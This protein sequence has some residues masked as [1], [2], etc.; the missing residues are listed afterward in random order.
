MSRISHSR[1]ILFYVAIIGSVLTL[2][3]M[4]SVY[5]EAN[6]K[7]PPDLNGRYFSAS[8]PPGCR[9][10]DRLVLTLQQSGIYVNGILTL[11]PADLVQ[12]PQSTDATSEEKFS[13]TGLWKP[14]Q[15]NLSGETDALMS[16]AVEGGAIGTGAAIAL[17]G[18]V[19]PTSF[20]GEM[21]YGSQTGVQTGKVASTAQ[22]W[23]FTAQR[24]ALA[25]P[26]EVH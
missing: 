7:A 24:Q 13:L 20:T 12:T 2:F 22:T 11:E 23:Q 10:G 16:C 3:Q 19:A 14:E 9:E 6:L 17:Q 26:K 1:H 4:V 8:A 5:G 15:I 21:T 18:Q 25:K